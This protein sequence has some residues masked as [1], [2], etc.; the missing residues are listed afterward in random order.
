MHKIANSSVQ[1]AQMHAEQA[2]E[3]G[4]SIERFGKNLQR[5]NQTA[6]EYGHFI[7][8]YGKITQHY[9]QKSLLYAQALERGGYKPIET[10]LYGDAV[11][12]HVN[13]TQAQ[14]QAVKMYT[15][16]VRGTLKALQS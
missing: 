16:L 4:K 6:Q 3:H 2:Q 14:I 12:A 9:A 10:C 11:E 8:E 15:Q 5:R 1:L 13:A 7:E